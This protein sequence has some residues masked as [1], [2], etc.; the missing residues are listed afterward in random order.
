MKASGSE[1]RL[2]HASGESGV[3]QICRIVVTIRHLSP[4]GNILL[5]LRRNLEWGKAWSLLAGDEASQTQYSAAS[6]DG[7][8][9][10]NH[11]IDVHFAT[12]SMQGWPRIIMR[13]CELD[14]YGRSILSGY[15]FAHLPT[16]PGEITGALT[17]AMFLISPQYAMT[18]PVLLSMH[19]DTMSWRY[20]AG[21]QADQ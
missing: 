7:V 17:I 20:A 5:L 21:D 13:L 18:Q 16:N 4:S 15:G 10:W 12:A 8:Q 9:I 6:D 1:I 3:Y 11:P 2:F 14:E 19:Q